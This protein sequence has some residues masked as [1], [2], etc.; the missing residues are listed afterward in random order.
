MASDRA[1][2]CT[3]GFSDLKMMVS[4][5]DAQS[6]GGKCHTSITFGRTNNAFGPI[7][8]IPK[9]MNAN[10]FIFTIQ[11]T[12]SKKVNNERRPGPLREKNN[13]NDET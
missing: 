1:S 3:F 10:T 4:L 9:T 5:A 7:F 2:G 11:D 12:D 6:E 8:M 13:E